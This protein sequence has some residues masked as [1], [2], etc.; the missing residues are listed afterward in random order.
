MCSRFENKETGLS[1]LEKLEKDSQG[2]YILEDDEELKQENIAPTNL[3]MSVIKDKD[4]YKIKK[5]FWGI[6]FDKIKKSPLIFNSRIESIKEKKYWTQIFHKNRCIVPAT[7]FYEWIEIDKTKIPL[8]IFLSEEDFFFIPSV[9]IK[10]E[11]FNYVSMIT[12][13]PNSFMRKFHN[14]MPVIFK[15]KEGLKYLKEK[16][17]KALELCSTISDKMTLNAEIAEELLTE[18]QKK[19]VFKQ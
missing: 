7:A 5:N 11:D 10:I 8:R 17:E 15:K 16:P 12:T 4:T 19:V 14:R 6:Q 1:I 2:N 18:I 9:Y 13:Q 3:I